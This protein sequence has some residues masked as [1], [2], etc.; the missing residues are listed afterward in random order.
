MEDAELEKC[1]VMAAAI[2]TKVQR[3]GIFREGVK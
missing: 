3:W 1:S 2:F